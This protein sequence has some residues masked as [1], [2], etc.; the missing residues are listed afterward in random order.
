MVTCVISVV[1]HACETWMLK[2]KDKNKLM[3]FKMRCYRRILNVRW[4]KITNEEIR[5]EWVARE[6][7]YRES[8]KEIKFI[9]AHLYNGR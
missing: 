7:S 5:K 8:S 1:L 2:K 6:T 3:A 4:Q 9:G